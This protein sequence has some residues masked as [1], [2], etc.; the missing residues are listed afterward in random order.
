MKL[1]GSRGKIFI[2]YL[3][4]LLVLTQEANA[5][6]PPRPVVVN[7]TG[8]GLAFGAFYQGAAGGTVSVSPAGV[9]SASGDVILFFGGFTFTAARFTIRGNPGTLITMMAGPPVVLNGS[10]GGSMTLTIGP[11]NPPPPF[12]LTNPWPV[13][14][15]FFM[16]G[17]LTVGSPAANPPGTYDGSFTIIFNQQ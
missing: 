13:P 10:N 9:R 3:L 11:A 5:Q 12:V 7:P 16:G 6:Y 17:T 15:D 14:M 2:L 4:L 8:Q 1:T